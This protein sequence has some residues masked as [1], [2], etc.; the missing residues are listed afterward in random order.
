MKK[1][2]EN[3]KIS[4]VKYLVASN[5][6]GRDGIGLE[7]YVN[8]EMVIEIFRDDESKLRTVSVYKNEIPLELLEQAVQEF[9]RKISWEYLD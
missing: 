2:N 6:G 7:V 4:N 1:S 8:D 9:K 3:N 5:V